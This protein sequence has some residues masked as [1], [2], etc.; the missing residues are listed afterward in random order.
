VVDALGAER[1]ERLSHVVGPGL[2]AGV[3]DSVQSLGRRGGEYITERFWGVADLG[4]VQADADEVL[5]VGERRPQGL[6]RL[7]RSP[8][9]QEAHDQVRGDPVRRLPFGQRLR[10]PREH[11]LRRHPRDTCCWAS[12]K[13]SA[14]RTPALAARAR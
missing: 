14:R 9:P 12:A 8:V 5:P 2:L 1:I 4:G 7:R 10:Q 6:H 11:R 3:G 13:I